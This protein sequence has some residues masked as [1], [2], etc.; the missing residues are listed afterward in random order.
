MENRKQYFQPG[1]T[2]GRTWV[3]LPEDISQRTYQNHKRLESKQEIK[4]LRRVGSQNKGEAKNNP[5][6]RGAMNP[7]RAY[8]ESFML[9][10][11]RKTQLSSGFIPLII[12]QS[13][14]QE[15]PLFTILG[16]FQENTR[17]KGQEKDYFKPE[18][19]QIRPHDTEIVGLSQRSAHKPQKI[20]KTPDRISKPTIRNDIPTQNEDN[21]VTPKSNIKSNELWFKM[22]Q[23]S[24]KTQKE[25]GKLHKDNVRLQELITLQNTTI[26]ALQEVFAKLSKESKETNKGLNHVLEKKHH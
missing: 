25:F 23:F 9:T 4:T 1:S 5:G 12:Q 18:E 17:I 11:S 10:R 22:S 15:S 2:L 20:V 6:F 19:E 13:I 21:V 14:G 8:S 3:K 16:S 26:H 7:E 24:E